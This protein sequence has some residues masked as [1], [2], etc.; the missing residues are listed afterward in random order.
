MP[1]VFTGPVETKASPTE[2]QAVVVDE[3]QEYER[4]AFKLIRQIVPLDASR[5]NDL[6]IVGDAHQRNTPHRVVSKPL[7]H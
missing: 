4:W 5:T 6:F 2:Y 1:Y 7:W 3:A